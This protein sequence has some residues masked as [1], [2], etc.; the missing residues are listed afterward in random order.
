MQFLLAHAPEKFYCR[1]ALGTR[2]NPKT[3]CVWT[4][5]F[6]LNTLRVD[7]ETCESEKKKLWALGDNYSHRSTATFELGVGGA[8]NLLPEKNYT[9]PQCVTAVQLH[10]NRSKQQKG[11]NFSRLTVVIPKIVFFLSH[12]YSIYLDQQPSEIRNL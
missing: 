4:G 10:S 5:D 12:A 6:D 1:G 8:V 9:M 2:V 7:R 3:G 11:S